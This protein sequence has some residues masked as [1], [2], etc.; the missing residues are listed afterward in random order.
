MMTASADGTFPP[1]AGVATVAVEQRERELATPTPRCFGRVSYVSRA[2]GELYAVCGTA[3]CFLVLDVWLKQKAAFIVGCAI[4][5]ISYICY[6]CWVERKSAPLRWGVRTDNLRAA[7]IIPFCVGGASLVIMVLYNIATGRTLYMRWNILYLIVL[8]PLWG[9][10]QQML[11]QGFFV[12]NLYEIFIERAQSNDPKRIV[13][14]I[15]VAAVGFGLI[16][17]TQTPLL[18]IGTFLL[19]CVWTPHFLHYRNVL[20]LGLLHGWIG[21]FFYF[22]MLRKDPWA[23]L[24]GRA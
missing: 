14:I 8:Y 4:G 11:V 17:G 7:C 16:H 1:P 22:L 2:A 23:D 6:C 21:A 5:W 24:V 15:A 10:L 20:P 12:A 19:A 18:T 9:T 3:L 13:A